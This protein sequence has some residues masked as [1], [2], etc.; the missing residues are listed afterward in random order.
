M[1]D[2]LHVAIVLILLGMLCPCDNPVRAE[3][4]LQVI[5]EDGDNAL[6]YSVHTDVELVLKTTNPT[7]RGL[8]LAVAVR[9]FRGVELKAEARKQ[10]EAKGQ[11]VVAYGVNKYYRIGKIK[12]V[13]YEWH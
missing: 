13:R 4:G 7:R 5:P 11:T 3:Q 9:P 12:G 10:A 1:K 2:P 8:R 6:V